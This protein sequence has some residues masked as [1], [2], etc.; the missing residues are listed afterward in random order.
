LIVVVG[1]FY[2]IFSL[3]GILLNGEVYACCM[4]SCL[5]YGGENWPV[6]ADNVDQPHLSKPHVICDSLEQFG[7]S[8]SKTSVYF[9]VADICRNLFGSN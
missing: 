9:H 4:R 5:I 8:V 6:V 1:L 2:W 7:A 3:C